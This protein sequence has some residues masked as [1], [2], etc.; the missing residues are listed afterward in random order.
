[1]VGFVVKTGERAVIWIGFNTYLGMMGSEEIAPLP[2]VR[3]ATIPILVLEMQSN[4]PRKPASAG[5]SDLAQWPRGFR[6]GTDIALGITLPSRFR[7]V[8]TTV[9]V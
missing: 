6:T 3:N 8:H 2:R 1:V 7:A 9:A 5:K 4:V